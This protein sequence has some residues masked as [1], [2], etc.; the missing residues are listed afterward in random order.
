M[1]CWFAPEDMKIDDRIRPR[2]DETTR[3]DDKLLLVLA[4]TS[5]TSQWVEQ[6][7]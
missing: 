3:L 4:K 1:R 7:V 6:E 5:V 2:I